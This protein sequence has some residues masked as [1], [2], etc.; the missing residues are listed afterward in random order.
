MSK[1]SRKV[2]SKLYFDFLGNSF[3]PALNLE[4]NMIDYNYEQ[5]NLFQVECSY[6]LPRPSDGW[7]RELAIDNLISLER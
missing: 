2:F 4:H 7:Q 6:V 5:Q 3:F 1:L